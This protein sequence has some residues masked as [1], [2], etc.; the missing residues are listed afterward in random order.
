MFDIF[1]LGS[2]T[3]YQNKFIMK[4]FS[5]LYAF[6]LVNY[7]KQIDHTVPFEQFKSQFYHHAVKRELIF[8]IL[9]YLRTNKIESLNDKVT[10]YD[11]LTHVVSQKYDRGIDI[12]GDIDRT[13]TLLV[14]CKQYSESQSI[15]KADVE[16]M[17]ALT[18]LYKTRNFQKDSLSILV[19]PYTISDEALNKMNDIPMNIA[20]AQVN[21]LPIDEIPLVNSTNIMDIT[22]MTSANGQLLNFIPNKSCTKTFLIKDK[23]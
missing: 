17:A 14:H 20:Y 21:D 8:K 3:I 5:S 12:V 16:Q 7:I 15:N 6:N 13:H 19:S 18:A 1:S 23:K 2:S 9:P 11:E 10:Y 4:G 22:K